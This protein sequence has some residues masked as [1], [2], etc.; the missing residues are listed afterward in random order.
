MGTSRLAAAV[1]AGLALAALAAAPG[2]PLPPTP[3]QPSVVLIAISGLGTHLG[4]YGAPVATPN[5]DR[6]SRMGRRFDRAY[7]QYPA[8]PPSFV[9]MMTGWRPDK[10]GVWSAPRSPVEGAESLQNRFRVAGYLAARIGPIYGGPAESAYRWAGPSEDAASPDAAAKRAAALLETH[11]GGRLFL[12]VGLDAMKAPADLLERYPQGALS[13]P[14]DGEWG[15]IP[16]ISISPARVDRPGKRAR[17]TPLAP[18][19]RRGLLGDR[20]AR[21]AYVDAQVGTILATLD[22]LE[23]WDRVAVVL[24]SDHGTYLGERGEVLRKDLLYEETLRTSLIV[25]TPGMK[26]PGQATEA[27]TELVDVYP[28][29]VE[30]CGLKKPRGLQGASFMPALLDPGAPGRPGAYSV[31]ARDAGS[32]G[33]SVRTDRYRYTEWPDGSEELYDHERDPHE[34]T[35]LALS[36]GGGAAL[37]GLRKLL[38]DRETSGAPPPPCRRPPDRRGPEG[39]T[40]S[41]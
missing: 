5:I 37:P 26:K 35:N 13:L 29:L 7:T 38:D 14:A 16:A 17:P 40:S 11:G 36:P 15:D 27:L 39:P 9:S 41:W 33:R 30:L 3:D 20:N 2:G 25:T 22:R 32:L 10:T 28:T 21:A 12:A 23:M 6:L 24:V 18:D 34:W 1:T 8:G 19:A 31:A 4:A